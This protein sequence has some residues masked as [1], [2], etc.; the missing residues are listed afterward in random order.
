[1]I[2]DQDRIL[3]CRLS[4][5]ERDVGKWTLPGGGLDFGESPEDGAIREIREETGLE[6]RLTG[7]ATV[8]SKVFQPGNS[9]M[10]AIRIFYWAEVVNG[11]LCVEVDGSTDGCQWFT[12]EEA[13]QLP[14]V[15]IAL[16]GVDMVFHRLAAAST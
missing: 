13:R 1:M 16:M 15:D 2:A 7:L 12:E 9:E 4:S 5:V 11:K 8:D 3:L 14:L 6:T 10:H